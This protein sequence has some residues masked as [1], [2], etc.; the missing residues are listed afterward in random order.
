MSKIRYTLWRHLSAPSAFSAGQCTFGE[1]SPGTGRFR[2][3]FLYTVLPEVSSGRVCCQ[4]PFT[5]YSQC[6]VTRLRSLCHPRP[7]LIV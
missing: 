5:R 1:V 2:P 7:L 3:S 6:Y 4:T